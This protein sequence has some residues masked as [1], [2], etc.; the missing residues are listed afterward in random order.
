MNN[1]CSFTILSTFPMCLKITKEKVGNTQKN[2]LF[3]AFS[4]VL[5]SW[6]D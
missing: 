4:L 2:L 1:G 5:S 6:S 3:Y